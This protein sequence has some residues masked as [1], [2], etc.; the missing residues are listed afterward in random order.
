M[1]YWNE[2]EDK[3][4]AVLSTSVATVTSVVDSSKATIVANYEGDSATITTVNTNTLNSSDS[5]AI[6]VT[7]SLNVSGTVSA[8]TIDTNT[9]SSNDSTVVTINDGLNVTGTIFADTITVSTISA[10]SDSTGTYTIT[11]P[12]TITLDPVDEIINDAPMRLV[13]K[14]VAQL[15]SLTA[16][17]G[18]MVF[19]TNETGGAIPVFYDGTNWRRVSDRAVASA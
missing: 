5:T 10:P 6:Q 4:K 14:T 9:I 3:F 11:S 2:G 15:G 17:A 16:S 8:D 1:F 13:S 18:A 12:T 19:C 7:D